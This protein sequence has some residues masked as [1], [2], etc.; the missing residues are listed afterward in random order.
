M[1]NEVIIRCQKNT[2]GWYTAYTR[3][4]LYTPIHPWNQSNIWGAW[5]RFGIGGCAPWP[6]PKTATGGN[7]IDIYTDYK[8]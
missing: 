8:R 2:R 3:V 7:G 5:A 1:T 6:Q 4:R